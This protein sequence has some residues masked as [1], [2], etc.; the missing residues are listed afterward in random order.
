ML[1]FMHLPSAENCQRCRKYSIQFFTKKAKQLFF[2]FGWW[3]SD[4]AGESWKKKR[5]GQHESWR[6]SHLWREWRDWRD[7]R[8]AEVERERDGI[9]L[10]SGWEH[11]D[12]LKRRAAKGRDGVGWGNLY[13][14][15]TQMY[16]QRNCID[17]F[18]N[19]EANEETKWGKYVIGRVTLWMSKVKVPWLSDS[20][21]DSLSDK[22]TYWAVLDS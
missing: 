1:H 17:I 2:N 19:L 14:M 21:T 15:N 7:C 9:G 8:W 11:C 12:I 3:G 16:S 13:M 6:V 22:V 4:W 20:V 5:R 10:T 18:D